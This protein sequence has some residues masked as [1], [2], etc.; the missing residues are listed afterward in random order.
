MII[1]KDITT[2]KVDA[3]VNAANEGL[4]PGGGVCG[5][6]FRGAGSLLETE[7]RKIGGCPTGEAVITFGYKLPAKYV[8]HAVG[9]IWRG[10][11]FGERELLS[12]AYE[13]S[14]D[15]ALS[16]DCET[17]AF[18]LISSGI[19]GYPKDMALHE[20]ITTIGGFLLRNR[21]ISVFLSVYPN[22]IGLPDDLRG[23]LKRF[24]IDGGKSSVFSTR[25][26]PDKTNPSPNFKDSLL[27][28]MRVKNLSQEE[29]GKRANLKEIVLK[30]I[31]SEERALSPTPSKKILLSL[32][33]G[34]GLDP[35]ETTAFLSLGGYVPDP[36]D[37]TDLITVFFLEKNITDVF[38]VSEAL[39]A[40]GEPIL[41]DGL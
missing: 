26:P 25:V 23:E 33:L 6:I 19:Y 22:K 11:G 35:L 28:L 36:S 41:N 32:C 38:L 31:L 14:L 4:F 24:L 17:I 1:K 10:G 5:A 15:L 21:E 29:L 18:P 2:L 7:C 13:K 16:H 3:V 39:Y 12:G 20:A 9:P 8:I 34:L 40:F 37:M 27:N 30:T